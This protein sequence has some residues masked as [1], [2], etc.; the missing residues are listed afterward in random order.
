MEFKKILFK[1]IWA[2]LVILALANLILFG[3][4]AY[5]YHLANKLPAF[6]IFM[7]FLIVIIFYAYKRRFE[8]FRFDLSKKG[9]LIIFVRACMPYILTTLFFTQCALLIS[10]ILFNMGQA[11]ILK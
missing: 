10:W 2:E 11:R 4:L 3:F 6:L 7:A 8:N 5:G 1:N 9:K